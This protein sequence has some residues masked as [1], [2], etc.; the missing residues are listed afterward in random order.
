MLTHDTAFCDKMAGSVNERKAVSVIYLYF[1]KAFD[2]I[3]HSIL[4]SKLGCYGLD[5]WTTRRLK[6][7]GWMAELT[8]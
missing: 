4:V 7:S 5:V 1:N 8:E 6:K 2:I 3:S